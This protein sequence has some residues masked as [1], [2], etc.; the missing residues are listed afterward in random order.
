MTEQ[1]QQ[2]QQQQQQPAGSLRRDERGEL[3]I[4]IP[5]PSLMTTAAL[6]REIFTLRE[7]LEVKLGSLNASLELIR[8]VIETRL[9]ASDQAIKLLQ[10][11][12][13]R[14]PS[15]IDEKIRALKDVHDQKFLSFEGATH[16]KFSSIEK[17]F[18]ERDVRTDQAAGAVKI[19]VDAA[20][21]AQKEAA[22]E[23]SKSNAAA[24]AKSE[25]ATTK[26]IDAQATLI[27][28]MTKG[29]DDKIGDVKDR[30]TRIEGLGVGAKESWGVIVAIIGVIIG[31]G[32]AVA[33]YL[34]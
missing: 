10:D 28:N 19:A 31:V 24:T 32:G 4:P 8:A 6:S 9:D 23:Q 12:A 2:Q 11:S 33:A 5:D 21:Q 3:N 29:F 26:L 7:L 20:L 17:Q 18:K 14:F 22:N 27:T 1:Q 16:E 15:R 13:D 25:A 34:K 30:I